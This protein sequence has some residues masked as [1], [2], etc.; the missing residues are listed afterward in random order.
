MD[1]LNITILGNTIKSYA[2]AAAIFIVALA[3]LYIFRKIVLK[4]LGKWAERTKTDVDDAIIAAIRTI[5][6]PFYFYLSLFIGFS[7]LQSADW[8]RNV[9][10]KI[11]IIWLVYKAIVAVNVLIDFGFSKKRQKEKEKGK[12]VT[13]L[14]LLAKITKAAVWAFGALFVLSNLGVNITSLV[15]GLGIGGIAIA[16][17]VQ[18][19]L[20]DLLSTF[21]IYF[22]KP[23][24]VGDFIVVGDKAG[25]VEKIGIK[26]THLRSSASGEQIIIS[27]KELTTAQVKNYK[28]IEERRQVFRIGVVYETTSEKLEK[29]PGIIKGIIESKK[30]TRFDRVHFDTFGDFALSFEISYYVK[31]SDY[32]EFK[33]I[34]QSILLEIKKAFEKEQ[35]EMAYPTQT[36]YVHKP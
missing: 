31:T 35:I 33:D 16:L 30:L 18:N 24:E 4:R 6:A 15:A 22:D 9:L 32:A 23:F 2:I 13:I 28:R 25:S 17:A 12:D 36:L 5:R 14:D 8:L 19:I 20:G 21:A 27:N 7:F 3:V 34:H 26:S 11:L 1:F 29:I 10:T